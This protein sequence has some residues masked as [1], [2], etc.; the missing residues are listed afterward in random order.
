MIHFFA[1]LKKTFRK[2]IK[3]KRVNHHKPLGFQ[4]QD[5]LSEII[6]KYNC[7]D[8]YAFISYGLQLSFEL[9]LINK[10]ERREDYAEK[11]NRLFAAHNLYEAFTIRKN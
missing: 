9:G 8:S 7:L 11:Y 10:I 4:Y 5:I 6:S 2:R 3:S 1:M